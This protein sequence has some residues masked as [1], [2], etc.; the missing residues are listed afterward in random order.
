MKYL[1]LILLTTLP[2]L[3]FSQSD[4]KLIKSIV[5]FL[6]SKKQLSKKDTSIHSNF[7][8]L[9]HTYKVADIDTC[10]NIV[11]FSFAGN[12]THSKPYYLISLSDSVIF[13]DDEDIFKTTQKIVPYIFN[14]CCP[15]TKRD[16][17]NLLENLISAIN[18]RAKSFRNW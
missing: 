10:K 3:C 5:P 18:R 6:I 9:V 12:A 1:L 16:K 13:L 7:N 2:S 8:D 15:L 17:I 11:I 14:E 4:S